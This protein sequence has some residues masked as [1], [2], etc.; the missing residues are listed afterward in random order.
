MAAG[1]IDRRGDRE[2]DHRR[3]PHAAQVEAHRE[4][5]D[6]AAADGQHR[7]EEHPGHDAR[8][9]RRAHRALHARGIQEF[10][11]EPARR[12][13]REDPEPGVLQQCAGECHHRIRSVVH[14]ARLPGATGGLALNAMPL[15]IASSCANPS[16]I[17]PSSWRIRSAGHTSRP[18]AGIAGRSMQQRVDEDHRAVQLE[19]RAA[20]S[21]RVGAHDLRSRVPVRPRCRDGSRP[22]SH[23]PRRLGERRGSLDP[24]ALAIAPFGAAKPVRH[25]HA[26][27]R[28]APSMRARLARAQ[29][30]VAARRLSARLKRVRS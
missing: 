27:M 13:A 19:A 1:L 30:P 3:Q 7:T 25:R 9:A 24:R 8:G 16:R 6:A 22:R 29:A 12:E 21:F 17:W 2:G 20:G 15:S 11:D 14:S 5:H 10:V 28:D 26:T 18:P 23:V 4:R